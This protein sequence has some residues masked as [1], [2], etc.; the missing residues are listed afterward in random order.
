[1]K[2][3]QKLQLSLKIF[4]DE[5]LRQVCKPVE[6][7][8]TELRDLIKEMLVLM[9]I[10]EGIGLAAPQVGMTKRLFVCEIENESLS[11]INPVIIHAGGQAEMI[12]GCL[13]LPHMQVNIKRSNRLY[14]RGLNDRGR[15]MQYELTGLW[16]RVFQHEMDHLDG[17]LICDHGENVHTEKEQSCGKDAANL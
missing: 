10:K 11:L 13:S 8:D 5:V 3:S 6:R 15:E 7:F 17:V 2:K 4:P 12:E 1:M 16:A 14:V 9:R